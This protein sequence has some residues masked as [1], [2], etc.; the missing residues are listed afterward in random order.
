MENFVRTFQDTIVRCWDKKALSDFHKETITYAQL[1][2][3]VA[4]MQA[5]WTAAGLVKGDKICLY[6]ASSKNWISVFMAAVSGGFVSVQ[7]FNGFLPSDAENLV[8]HSDSKILYLE[9]RLFDKMNCSNMKNVIAVFDI[10]TMEMLYG[11][12][13]AKSFYAGIDSMVPTFTK[14]DV[15]L[16]IPE[17]DD[18]CAIMYTSGSTGNPKGVMLN[19]R[20]F[21]VNVESLQDYF[22]YYPD[23]N[24]VS[25]L[26]FAHIFGLLCDG[27]IPV[28]IGMHE[29]V[30]GLPP[31]PANVKDAMCELK[32]S[33]FFAV[34]LILTKFIDYV[35][36]KQIHTPEGEAK[37]EDYENNQEFCSELHDKVIEALGGN[38]ELFVTGG[39]AIPQDL[40]LLLTRK[41]QLPFITGYGMTETCPLISAGH[42]GTYK[43]KSC[44]E[45]SHKCVDLKVESQDP[46]HIAGQVLVKGAAVFQG[47]YKNPEATKAAFT[48]DG[49]FMTGDMG[50]VDKDDTLF[51]VGRC[52]N[53]LL[54]TNGQNIYPEEI[55]VLLNQLPYVAESI[56]V[57]RDTK[58]VA[59]IV[60]NA[61]AA[62]N[63]NLS[64]E[65][66]AAIMKQNLVKL[67]QQVP[68]YSAVADYELQT[69]PFAKTPKGSIRRFLYS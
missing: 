39:A 4:K 46:E 42:K 22:P 59:L 14:E 48:E 55:E 11:T 54:S 44:G 65:T 18:I 5:F 69:Q 16:F 10:A 28:T 63:D 66:L 32:P 34:P 37:L 20:N 53:M 51:L 40:E 17:M 31:I 15:R 13:E 33:I 49:W 52:K 26:P 57:Q 1:G 62:T 35:V 2:H 38:V 24:Y 61:D 27:I 7:L 58:L 47:Y 60:P 9:K 30:L 68:G 43:L 67:N 56:I 50:T 3:N 23:S 41:L 12:D 8:N 6:A 45:Y 19:V 36:G 29:T 64:A 21:S 25:I